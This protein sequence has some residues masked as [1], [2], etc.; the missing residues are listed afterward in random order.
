MA[1]WRITGIGLQ[2][3]LLSWSG[4]DVI[5]DPLTLPP[6]DQ[7]DDQPVDQPADQPLSIRHVRPP[8]SNIR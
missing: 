1:A 7:P 2:G 6:A 4:Y 5:T 8:A 3:H